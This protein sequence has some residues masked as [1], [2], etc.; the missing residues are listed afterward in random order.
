MTGDR[1]AKIRRRAHEI[2]EEQGKREGRETEFWHQ[3]ERKWEAITTGSHPKKTAAL[4]LWAPETKPNATATRCGLSEGPGP[5][6]EHDPLAL[7]SAW[8]R[9]YCGTNSGQLI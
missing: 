7:V 3:A 1:E 4:T 6:P 2:W 5:V 9:R 8:F